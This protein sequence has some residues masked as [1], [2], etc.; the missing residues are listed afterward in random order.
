M[1]NYKSLPETGGGIANSGFLA[2]VGDGVA[3][4]LVEECSSRLNLVGLVLEFG[5]I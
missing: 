2:V 1:Y 5:L 4:G 3:F